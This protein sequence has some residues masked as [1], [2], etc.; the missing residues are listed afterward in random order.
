LGP[1]RGESARACRILERWSGDDSLLLISLS[2][3]VLNEV[4]QARQD[5]TED[6]VAKLRASKSGKSLDRIRHG[7]AAARKLGAVGNS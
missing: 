4:S 6:R 2:Q 5:F 1:D 7:G 3:A